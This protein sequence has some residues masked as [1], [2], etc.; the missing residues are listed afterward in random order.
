[1]KKLTKSVVAGLVEP[2][3]TKD[4]S[5]MPGCAGF[6]FGSAKTCVGLTGTN[7]VGKLVVTCTAPLMAVNTTPVPAYWLL[8]TVPTG[9]SSNVIRR[10][11]RSGEIYKA[12]SG[13]IWAK[14]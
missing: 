7:W 12:D 3:A 6:G 2:G 14:P 13:T 4:R 10:S 11:P 8:R 1:M 9:T 5:T